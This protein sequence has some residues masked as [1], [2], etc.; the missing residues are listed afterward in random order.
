MADLHLLASEYHLAGLLTARVVT[1]PPDEPVTAV[2]LRA[3]MAE[4]G[5]Q[6]LVLDRP[7][8]YW[9]DTRSM[10]ATLR[11]LTGPAPERAIEPTRAP[12]TGH[13]VALA[14]LWTQ[15]R[16]LPISRP[17][18]PLMPPSVR[19]SSMSTAAGSSCTHPPGPAE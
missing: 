15:V 19:P 3:E 13:A 17:G 4:H 14:A 2:H 18:T 11:R 10:T 7:G 12:M 9:T 8:A 6:A 1:E 16:R 5:D